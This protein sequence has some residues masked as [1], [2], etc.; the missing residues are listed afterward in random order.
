MEP[1]L[2]THIWPATARIDAAG[3]LE[4]GGCAL[5]DLAD[6]YGTPLYLL[7]EATLRGAMRAYRAAF[8]A[9]YPAPHGV[10]Y[11]AKALLN[12]ALAQ[13][14]AQEGL[15]L[16]V[17]SGTELL[18]A[19]RAGLPM[20]RVHL[21]GNAKT[22]AELERALAW[23]VGAVVIDNL[24]ELDQLCALSAGRPTPQGVLLRL[25]P[26][27]AAQTHA[28]IATGGADSKFG[29]PLAAVEAAAAR[30]LAAPGL[31][32]LGLH[33]HIGSQLFDLE[34]LRACVAVL[35]A[36]AARLRDRLGVV[37]EEISPGGGL[38]APYTTEMPATDIAAY[39]TTLAAAVNT[40]CAAHGL[41]LPR[42][43]VE[44]GR[45]IVARAGVALYRVVATRRSAGDDAPDA[46][47]PY[48]HIDGGM[49]DNIRPALYGARYTALLAE[50]ASAAPNT[51]VNVAGRYCESGDVLL[52][53]VLLP[54]AAPGDLLAVAVAGAYTLSMASNYNLTPRPAL[55]L[56]GDGAARVIQRRETEE[57][58]LGR[59]CGI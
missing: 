46:P 55:L 56:V 40:G 45:S 37:V 33:A 22:C 14:V 41:P 20:E 7:D 36:T 10:H 3:R 12:T 42:L 23:G 43:T 54:P 6:R 11:A 34:E 47:L 31:R 4:I 18:A 16:D 13:I 48:L 25:A 21:H 52:R 9:A 39:A 51:R 28:H 53:D 58:V 49:A 19:R 15:G 24:D 30:A 17:V 8:A 26:A 57:E 44:P 38:G 2:P 32:L 5:A 27:I 29:L 59:D 50:R 1:R 35:L